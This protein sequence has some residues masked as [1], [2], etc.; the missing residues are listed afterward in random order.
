MKKNLQFLDDGIVW[1]IFDTLNNANRFRNLGQIKWKKNVFKCAFSCIVFHSFLSLFTL[2]HSTWVSILLL[3]YEIMETLWNGHEFCYFFFHYEFITILPVMKPY[4][5][6]WP[7]KSGFTTSVM[8]K[9]LG[10]LFTAYC[11]IATFSTLIYNVHMYFS[12]YQFLEKQCDN[13]DLVQYDICF[14]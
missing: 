4:T 13:G 12:V 8:F 11:F 2:C 5:M 1:Y 6:E 14:W 9:A 10:N 3:D 7:L